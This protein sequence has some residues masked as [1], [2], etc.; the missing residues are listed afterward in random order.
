MTEKGILSHN[1][2]FCYYSVKLMVIK[3]VKKPRNV[4]TITYFFCLVVLWLDN[5]VAN[6]RMLLFQLLSKKKYF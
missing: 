6:L 4:K 2:I 5:A 3:C 1:C